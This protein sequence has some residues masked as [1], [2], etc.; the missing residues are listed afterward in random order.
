MGKVYH[1]MEGRKYPEKEF[2]DYVPVFENKNKTYKNPVVFK[3]L[4]LSNQSPNMH[5][6]K[7]LVSYFSINNTIINNL[8]EIF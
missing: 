8:A 2:E 3:Y 7:C 1:W 6:V 5:A 4:N